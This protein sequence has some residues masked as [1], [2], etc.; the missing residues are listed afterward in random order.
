MGR[1]DPGTILWLDI[2]GQYATQEG[3]QVL[4]VG[5]ITYFVTSPMGIIEVLADPIRAFVYLGILVGFCAFFALIWLEV[6]GLGPATV[7]RQLVGSG[8]QIPGHRRSQRTIE[9]ILKR[10]IPTVTILGGIIIALI[11]G[12][13]NFLGVFGSGIGILLAVGIVYQYYEILMRERAAEMYPA[14]KRVLGE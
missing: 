1:P 5:G 11:A 3:G 8:M 12:L 9:L 7:A 6:G 4:T 13:S 2:I 14:L 10:Y